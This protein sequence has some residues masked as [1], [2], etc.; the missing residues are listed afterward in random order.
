MFDGINIIIPYVIMADAYS[1]VI[2]FMV[3]T[4]RAAQF[5]CPF[6]KKRLF[7]KMNWEVVAKSN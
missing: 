5:F 1:L 3:F 2:L 6:L 7:L 4:V